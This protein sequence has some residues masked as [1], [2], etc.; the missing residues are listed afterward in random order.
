MSVSWLSGS[1]LQPIHNRFKLSLNNPVGPQKNALSIQYTS[2]DL[3]RIVDS[4]ASAKTPVDKAP[5]TY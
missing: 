3:R 1:I 2:S 5:L 4:G